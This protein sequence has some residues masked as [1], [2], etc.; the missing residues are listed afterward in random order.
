MSRAAKTGRLV[1]ID[2]CVA[3]RSRVCRAL[4]EAV[5]DIC[6]RMAMTE[7]LRDEWI[8]HET[9]DTARW[10]SWMRRKDKLQPV[11]PARDEDLCEAVED[12]GLS[13]KQRE[14]MRKDMHLVEAAL[15]CGGPVISVDDRARRLFA[16]AAETVPA[17]RPIVWVNPERMGEAALRAWLEQGAPAAPELT[18]GYRES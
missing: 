7:P 5:K 9:Q 1:I 6:H 4:F 14:A 13:R 15:E 11:C 12:T 16:T 8:R 2:A 10:R 18:L 3:Q 17:L